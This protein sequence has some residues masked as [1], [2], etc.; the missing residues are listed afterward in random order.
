[1]LLGDIVQVR[2]VAGETATDSATVP[3]NPF[4]LVAVKTELPAAPELTVTLVGL[5]LKAK[6]CMMNV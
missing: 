4:T 3:V 2:P 5:A 1:M 6:S